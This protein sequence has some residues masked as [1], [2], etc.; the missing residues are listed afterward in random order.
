MNRFLHHLLFAALCLPPAAC[1][2]AEPTPAEHFRTPP[3]AA[4][5]W[6]FWYWMHAAVTRE[7]ISA[8]L[9]AMRDAG[10][11]GAY[12][13]TINGPTDPPHIEPPVLP[14]TEPWWELVRFAVEEA[15]RLGLELGFHI[16]DGFATAGGPWITPELSMQE[17]TWSV[18]NVSTGDAK[19]ELLQPPTHEGFYRDIA[20]LAFPTPPG[21]G[22]SSA[23]EPVTITSSVVDQEPAALAKPGNPVRFRSESPC[24][25]EYEFDEPFTARCVTITPDGANSQCQRFTIE[26]SD[27]G[28]SYRKVAQ[29]S[30]PRHGWQ[31]EGRPVTHAFPATTARQF[32]FRW[33]PVGTEPGA[34]DLDSAKW[35]PVLKL[36]E[37]HLL[38]EPRIDNIEGKSAIAWRLSASSTAEQILPRDCI[39]KQN[40]LDLTPKLEPTGQLS[41][42]P[43]AGEWS[44]LRI[45]HTSTGKRNATAAAPGLECDKLSAKA[46]ELQYQRWFGEAVRRVGPK[47]A[48]RV[49]SRL[50][51]DSWECGS[52]NWTPGFG[53]EFQRRRGYNLT[54]YLPLLAG[55]PIDSASESER[56]L[57]DI[58]TTIAELLDEKYY[59]TLAGKARAG[60]FTFS[61]ECTAPTM[62]GDG[63]AH[64]V[65]LD[66]PMGEFWLKSPTHDKPNDI[67]DAVSAAH[68]FGK[69]VIGAEAFTQL[70]IEWNETPAL[71]KPLADRHFA[72]GVNQLTLH[73]ML[74][75]PWPD[76]YPG[77]TLGAIGTHFGREQTWLPM[78]RGFTDYLA[79]CQWLLQQ[80]EPVVDIAILAPENIPSRAWR[81]DQLQ[82]A[83]PGLI[84][85]PTASTLRARLANENQPITESPRGVKHAANISGAAEWLDPLAGHKYDTVSCAALRNLAIVRGGKLTFPGGA[86]YHLLIV[87]QPTRAVPLANAVSRDT[88]KTLARLA[89]EGVQ[90]LVVDGLKSL[91][92]RATLP[93]V[94]AAQGTFDR[95][96]CIPPDFVASEGNA[97]AVE[98]AWTHRTAEWGEIYLIAN[99]AE[100]ARTL[101]LSLR[102]Q[103]QLVEVWHP[104]TGEI[105]TLPFTPSSDRTRVSIMVQPF[106]SCFIVLPK[107]PTVSSTQQPNFT[108]RPQSLTWDVR[109]IPHQPNVAV[110]AA[111]RLKQLTELGQLDEQVKQFSGQAAYETKFEL[112]RSGVTW[113]D[114]GAVTGPAEVELNGQAC[115][116]AWTSPYRVRIDQHVRPGDNK[117]T[118]R[119]MSTWRNRLLHES[120][121]PP[122]KRT[123][124]MT[125][126]Y[127]FPSQSPDP[128]GLLGPV[129]LQAEE[130]T[131]KDA[132]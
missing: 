14:N 93:V 80:G 27:N 44:I 124:W 95:A 40:I 10:L 8:D 89:E 75:N 13:M 115:G 19:I 15:D 69:R 100:R 3:A 36:K 28:Q 56:V 117:L 128:F 116:I 17:V 74:H 121:L 39:S 24:W 57:G 122:A 7:G 107:Q 119:V 72:V 37:I 86:A 82:G 103:A 71:L 90:M 31:D 9:E 54:K 106:E 2:V 35:A 99:Q 42:S 33:T 92:P 63:L 127:E 126:P 79:R 18:T 131:A 123:T 83:V 23:T 49:L 132:K 113:L 41:W 118:V 48:P 76:R 125:A 66:Q 64:F 5:P 85:E 87:P 29:L 62:V 32:R 110:P 26:A 105:D 22:N 73:V 52:Q 111:R 21:A 25:I 16:C 43:P 108:S 120:K 129:S 96:E 59:G 68:V 45:G 102:Q 109:F 88:A 1:C 97:L 104:L 30:P 98:V 77:I 55:Y 60:G 12:L 114:L 112:E 50:H 4:R 46:T 70:R 94:S 81:P 78:A 51:V 101:E 61:G 11:G 38:S 91:D 58:R 34:E 53:G 84:A 67:L 65:H 6:V 47:L 20:V 130:L